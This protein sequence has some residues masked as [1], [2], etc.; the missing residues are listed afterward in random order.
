MD[1]DD[2]LPDSGTL[3]NHAPDPAPA[4]HTSRQLL[5]G[6][7]MRVDSSRDASF[8]TMQCPRNVLLRSSCD[9]D[10]QRAFLHLVYCATNL[11]ITAGSPCILPVYDGDGKRSLQTAFLD[12]ESANKRY[13]GKAARLKNTRR[14][15]TGILAWKVRLHCATVKALACCF[16]HRPYSHSR[17]ERLR[18]KILKSC[19]LD[20]I[21]EHT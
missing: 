12:F 20:L 19:R 3:N 13:L 14:I 7:I 18:Y 5:S 15:F 6:S 8:L 21:H 10:S 2:D 17:D 16:T 9:H 4:L 11:A 1:I